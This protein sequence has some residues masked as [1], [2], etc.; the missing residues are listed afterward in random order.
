MFLFPRQGLGCGPQETF[1]NCADIRIVRSSAQ[2]PATDN[3]RAIMRYDPTSKS[4]RSPLVVRSQVTSQNIL[5]L[6][7]TFCNPGVCGY[8]GVVHLPGH[9]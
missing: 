4:G 9:V 2:L 7:A 6:M 3:P 1:R 5:P 8:R